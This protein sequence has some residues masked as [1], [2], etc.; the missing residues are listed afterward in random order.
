M[1]IQFSFISRCLFNET[2]VNIILIFTT[3]CTKLPNFERKVFEKSLKKNTKAKNMAS[4]HLNELEDEI[5]YHPITNGR[6]DSCEA[7]EEV[8]EEAD[9]DLDE[10]QNGVAKNGSLQDEQE[11]KAA[12]LRIIRRA[13]RA[14]MPRDR[15]YSTSEGSHFAPSTGGPKEPPSRSAKN[16]R[17]SRSGFGRGLPKKGKN[18]LIFG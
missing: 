3:D 7:I 16:S 17:K 14:G 15:A 8:D 13:K 5:S 4:K 6:S 18:F 2:L 10:I 12:A 1:K 9:L 11:R